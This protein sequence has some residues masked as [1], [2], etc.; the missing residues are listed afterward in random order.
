MRTLHNRV[1]HR[2]A[3]P[4]TKLRNDLQPS[5]DALPAFLAAPLWCIR[6]QQPKLTTMM[7]D[8]AKI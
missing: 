2:A 5:S 6:S 4:P 3:P 7:T 8:Y 1:A